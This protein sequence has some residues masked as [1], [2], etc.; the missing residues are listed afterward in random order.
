M[1]LIGGS[2]TS[3][4]AKRLRAWEALSRW[5]MVRRGLRWP[6]G[7]PDIIDYL[8]ER[9]R[10]RSSPSFPRSLLAAAA[11][12]E[13]R[14]GIGESEKISRLDVVKRCVERETHGAECVARE[15]ESAHRVS[16]QG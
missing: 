4:I 12:M 13:S 6:R 2:R 16:G 10:E 15:R 14:V 7:A 8:W 1:S 9:I 3:T 5:L 11:W